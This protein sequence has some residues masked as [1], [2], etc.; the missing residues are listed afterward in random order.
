MSLP[1]IYESFRKSGI[2]FVA[3][4]RDGKFKSNCPECRE[5]NT[6]FVELDADGLGF[7]LLLR[8]LR[9]WWVRAVASA[10]SEG[11]RQRRPAAQRR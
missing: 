4:A 6:N 2:R 5:Q 10:A 1:P 3:N 9:L 11:R 7:P 8:G